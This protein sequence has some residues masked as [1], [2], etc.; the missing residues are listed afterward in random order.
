MRLVD[1]SRRGTCFGREAHA[2]G[3]VDRGVAEDRRLPAAEG[4]HATGTGMGTFTPIMPTVTSRSKR[5]A[6]L[7]RVKMATPLP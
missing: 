4:L 1:G 2:L 5:R 7:S 3:P 6:A